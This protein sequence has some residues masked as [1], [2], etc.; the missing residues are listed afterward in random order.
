MRELLQLDESLAECL[1]IVAGKLLQPVFEERA[2]D[3]FLVGSRG[4]DMS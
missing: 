4:I 2:D 3:E 1:R